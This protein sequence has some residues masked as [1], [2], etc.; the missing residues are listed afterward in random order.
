MSNYVSTKS[1]LS[2]K[3]IV[4][5]REQG[6]IVIE[7]FNMKQLNTSS[8]DV[9]IGEYYFR[10]QKLKEWDTNI[11][12]MYSETMVDKVWGKPQMAKPYSEYIKEGLILDN[13]HPNEKIIIIQPG[14][15]ILAHTNE[16]I[17]GVY[18]VTTMMKSRSSLGRNFIETCSCAGFG[19]VGYINRWT[20]EIT[21]NSTNYAI[22]LIVG[23]R[24][25]QIVFLDTDGILANNYASKGKYQTASKLEELMKNWKPEDMLP[26]M[27]NDY[28]VIE[29]QERYGQL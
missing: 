13:V 16:Y 6:D 28:E 26:K 19:D 1:C 17:G 8:Y 11:Y 20:M 23:R 7:P 3:A 22:P 10:E 29:M 21:N 12:N 24:V 5:Y 14:E 25:A 4:K 27:Y 2:D 9:T 18:K 15:R